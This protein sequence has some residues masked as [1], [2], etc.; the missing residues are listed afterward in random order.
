MSLIDENLIEETSIEWFKEIGYQFIHG[1]DI[2]P[3]SKSPERDDLRQVFLIDRLKSALIRL[4]PEVPSKTIDAAVLKITNPNIPGLVATKPGIFG[5]VIF[6]TAASIVL[7]GT[8]GFNL[9]SADFKRSIRKTCR[10][11]SLSGDLESG[12][13]SGP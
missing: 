1:P 7:L 12:A 5:L 3:D 11:S 8:S 10:K 4:N 13:I 9:M 2:A 6:R